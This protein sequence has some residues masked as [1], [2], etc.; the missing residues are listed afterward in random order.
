MKNNFRDVDDLRQRFMAERKRWRIKQKNV[1]GDKTEKAQRRT[2]SRVSS[3]ERGR[4]PRDIEV[5]EN[6]TREWEGQPRPHFAAILSEHKDR[7]NE[8]TASRADPDT[9]WPG[10]EEQVEELLRLIRDPRT[11][12]E[13]KQ[14]GVQKFFRLHLEIAEAHGA[15]GRIE[16]TD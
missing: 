11:S 2:Q 1:F 13:D 16:Q 15:L 4:Y 14:A 5:F 6:K 9:P 8:T 12:V 3:F 7:D 10:I